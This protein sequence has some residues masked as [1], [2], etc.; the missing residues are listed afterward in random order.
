MHIHHRRFGVAAFGVL[1]TALAA[2][3]LAVSLGSAQAKGKALHLTAVTKKDHHTISGDKVRLAFFD[4]KKDVGSA[5]FPDCAAN[6][7]SF[8][9]GGKVSIDQVG[10]GLDTLITWDCPPVAPFTC[11]PGVG[12]LEKNG[13]AVA[14]IKL[15]VQPSDIDRGVRFPALITKL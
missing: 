14:K 4:G 12:S 3:F 5:S 9:C 1:L 10:D 7:T 13:A 11:K 8:I 2:G 15:K 6:A